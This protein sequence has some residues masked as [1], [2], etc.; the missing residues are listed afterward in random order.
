MFEVVGKEV[1]YL[2]RVQMGQLKLDETL[3]LGSYRELTD[4]EL[5]LLKAK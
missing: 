3:P 1:T 4:T 5:E 2:K